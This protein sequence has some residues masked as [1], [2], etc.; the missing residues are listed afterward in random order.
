MACRSCVIYVREDN[1][2]NVHPLSY[3]NYNV[4]WHLVSDPRRWP[5]SSQ[6]S[7]LLELIL[8]ILWQWLFPDTCNNLKNRFMYK[9]YQFWVDFLYEIFNKLVLLIKSTLFEIMAWSQRLQSILFKP[10]H[11]VYLA[12]CITS[13]RG[14]TGQGYS[15]C[16]CVNTP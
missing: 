11:S 10:V 3:Y 6:C 14:N 8:P 15:V 7:S 1:D 13:L 12:T 2:S 16:M 4:I 5:I 9:T